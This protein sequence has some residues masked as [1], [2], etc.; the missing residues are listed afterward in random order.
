MEEGNE[1]IAPVNTSRNINWLCVSVEYSSS[2]W[3]LPTRK[4]YL[5]VIR[6]FG[7]DGDEISLL[8]TLSLYIEKMGDGLRGICS[9]P[10]GGTHS[11]IVYVC[12]CVCVVYAV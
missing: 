3:Y 9:S 11:I 5:C 10:E 1:G 8:G 6:E 2:N 4:V 12:V 7:C